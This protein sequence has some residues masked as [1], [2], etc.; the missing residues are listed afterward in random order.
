METFKIKASLTRAGV[1][2]LFYQNQ[3]PRQNKI[4]FVKDIIKAEFRGTFKAHS[5]DQD[6]ITQMYLMLQ[7]GIIYRLTDVENEFN[8]SI[9]L[10]LRTADDYDFFSA[11][12]LLKE[13]TI[14]YVKLN[15]DV[16]NGP[17]YLRSDHDQQKIRNAIAKEILFVPSN[18][19]LFEQ[20][21]QYKAA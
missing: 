7:L 18:T 19:Q 14:Y 16:V 1:E 13:N 2:D 11:K 3:T 17:H 12:D 4:F 9:K 10:S 21:K 8:Q 5:S 20:F 15:N 6:V